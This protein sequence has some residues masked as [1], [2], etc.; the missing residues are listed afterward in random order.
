MKRKIMKSML[1]IALLCGTLSGCKKD[2]NEQPSCATTREGLAGTYRLTAL[3]YK[4]SASAP[5]QDFLQ[6]LDA[7]ERDDLVTLNANGS[8]TYQDAGTVCSPSGN[9]SGTWSVSGSTL[10]SDGMINGTISSYDCRT[11]VYHLDNILVPGDTYIFT[12]VKQ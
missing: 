1:C 11:L 2:K 5:E 3:K 8:Y 4:M 12:M 9:D 10:T 7:C 6:Y